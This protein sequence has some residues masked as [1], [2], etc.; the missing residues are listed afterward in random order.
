MTEQKYLKQWY[1]E[2]KNE[3]MLNEYTF[4]KKQKTKSTDEN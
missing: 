4:E 1:S 3:I 2:L